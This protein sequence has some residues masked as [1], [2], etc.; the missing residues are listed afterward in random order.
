M[1]EDYIQNQLPNDRM[2]KVIIPWRILVFIIIVSIGAAILVSSFVVSKGIFGKPHQKEEKIEISSTIINKNEAVT[3][4]AAQ[5]I[6]R[7]LDAIVVAGTAYSQNQRLL[8]F[9]NEDRWE[10]AIRSIAGLLKEDINGPERIYL[11]DTGGT[12]MADFPVL[13]G[14][15]G[16]NYAS[17]DWFKGVTE[18]FK[19]PYLSEVHARFPS[20]RFNVVSF[21][22]PVKN[23]K[24]VPIAILVIET[25]ADAFLDW[26]YE[27]KVGN[28]GRLFIVD[29]RGQIVAHPNFAPQGE[30]M[31]FSSERDVQ[32]VLAGQ[33]GT[34]I[35][36]D[37]RRFISS[38]EP[39]IDDYKW[40]VVFRI[41]VDEAK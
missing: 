18:N 19:Q 40:G 30:I 10:D 26:V 39:L 12:L 6:K 1:P 2:H 23:A 20:P 16:Q 3:K 11:T 5:V 37:N 17:K 4:L 28:T 22:F 25:K 38:Y 27:V 9:I 24:G 21:A 29:Q 32:R 33:S 34:D 36:L 13:S 35:F 14:A 31:D 41:S 15:K 8:T 7:H